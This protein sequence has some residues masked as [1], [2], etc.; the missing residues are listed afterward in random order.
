MV[1]EV[2]LRLTT[3]KRQR[4][5]H[6]FDSNTWMLLS[7]LS[8]PLLTVLLQLVWEQLGSQ[9]IKHGELAKGPIVPLALAW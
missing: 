3:S 6:I 9:D 7:T 4:T 5:G 8:L 2:D 1:E